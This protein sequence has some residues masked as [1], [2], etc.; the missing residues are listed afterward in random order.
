MK[1]GSVTKLDKRNKITPKKIDDDGMWENCDIIVIFPVYGRF[2]VI[3]K[4][5]F[6]GIVCETYIFSNSN[7]LSYKNGKQN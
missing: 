2:R 1:L 5:D 6:E 3:R 7:L 4:P